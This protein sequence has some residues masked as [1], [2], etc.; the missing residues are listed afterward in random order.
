[1]WL[2][3]GLIRPKNPPSHDGIVL[4]AESGLSITPDLAENYAPEY[5]PLIT[6]FIVTPTDTSISFVIRRS[7]R[8]VWKPWML[9][10]LIGLSL[11]QLGRNAC[12]EQTSSIPSEITPQIDPALT[13]ELEVS[14]GYDSRP[15]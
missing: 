5:G 8:H 12:I 15:T 7:M 11:R 4:D 13:S 10:P 3:S 1:M 6:D 2:T 14:K 9:M